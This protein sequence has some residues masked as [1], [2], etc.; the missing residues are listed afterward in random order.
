MT[1]FKP[2]TRYTDERKN[3]SYSVEQDKTLAGLL[4]DRYVLGIAKAKYAN[5]VLQADGQLVTNLDLVRGAI[6]EATKRAEKAIDAARLV[7]GKTAAALARATKTTKDEAREAQA[8]AIQDMAVANNA[9]LASIALV[10]EF[11][12]HIE[13]GRFLFVLSDFGL[14]VVY[15]QCAVAGNPDLPPLVGPG[16]PDKA[17]TAAKRKR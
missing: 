13:Q 6:A 12:Q 3:L 8:K 11:E 5:H 15:F 10:D 1:A 14:P 9:H 7:L 17:V 2:G 16:Q 4:D